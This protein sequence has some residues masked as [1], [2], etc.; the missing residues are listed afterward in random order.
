VRGT[1]DG[2]STTQSAFQNMGGNQYSPY[3][4]RMA[5]PMAS[6][7]SL[8]F[9]ALSMTFLALDVDFSLFFFLWVLFLV[10]ADLNVED[11]DV[12][13]AAAAPPL[14][15]RSPM[16]A[17]RLGFTTCGVLPLGTRSNGSSFDDM[18]DAAHTVEQ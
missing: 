4:H 2:L 5:S 13:D 15:S 9:M 6:A 16:V 14:S 7:A 10:P 3:T 1:R 8:S 11:E 18:D 17:G 12:V